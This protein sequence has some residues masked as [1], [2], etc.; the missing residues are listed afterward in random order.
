MKNC[1]TFCL[2]ELVFSAV[3]LALHGLLALDAPL[4]SAQSEDKEPGIFPWW[5]EADGGGGWESKMAWKN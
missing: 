3:T 2:L 5:D 4:H 1:V